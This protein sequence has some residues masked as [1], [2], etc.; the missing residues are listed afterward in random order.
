M[1]HL[2]GFALT[3][4]LIYALP[5]G[6]LFRAFSLHPSGFGRE[7]FT[8]YCV[9]APL[10]QPEAAGG[11]FCLAWAIVFQSWLAVATRGGSGGRMT[12]KR[13]SSSWLIFAR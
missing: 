1:P 12:A 4:G 2:P 10:Y 3:D 11:V 13:S 6:R 5:V 9:V 8:M 7:R